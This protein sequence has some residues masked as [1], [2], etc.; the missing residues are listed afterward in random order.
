MPPLFADPAV[1]VHESLGLPREGAPRRRDKQERPHQG[2]GRVGP[3]TAAPPSPPQSSA[4]PYQGRKGDTSRPRGRKA[5]TLVVVIAWA[6]RVISP[7]WS[8]SGL[9]PASSPAGPGARGTAAAKGSAVR[10]PGT[11][12]SVD[13]LSPPPRSFSL[14]SPTPPAGWLDLAALAV[15]GSRRPVASFGGGGTKLPVLRCGRRGRL[16]RA[17]GELSSGPGSRS[18][19]PGR[20]RGIPEVGHRGENIRTPAPSPI[21]DGR[22]LLPFVSET[23]PR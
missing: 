22:S 13:V 1:A 18:R 20:R 3:G 21:T 9:H 6:D 15:P 11:F 7:W 14:D 19:L 16:S 23:V 4:P 2:G 12:G 17:Q 10:R 8:G 5:A